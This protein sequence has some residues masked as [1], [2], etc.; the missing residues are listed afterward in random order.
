MSDDTKHEQPSAGGRYIR[1][2]DGSLVRQDEPEA[3]ETTDAPPAAR[4]KT[5]KGK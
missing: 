4:T 2:S 3:T 5:P 1:Q